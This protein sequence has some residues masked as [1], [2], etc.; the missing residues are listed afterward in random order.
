MAIQKLFTSLS[1]AGNPNL[2]VGEKGRIWY[3]SVLGFSI[4]DG[5]TP[6]GQ[7]AAV[8]VTNANIGYQF[9]R[10]PS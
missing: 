1:K 4:S 9:C 6:G 7:A 3:D 2:Y 8:A 5:V 10:N